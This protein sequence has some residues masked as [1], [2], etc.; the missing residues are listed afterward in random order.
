MS[1][2]GWDESSTKLGTVTPD[3]SGSFQ[4]PFKALDDL[5]GPHRIEARSGDKKLAQTAFTISPSAFALSP[6]SGSAGTDFTVHLKGG[7]WTETAN[8]YLL[9]YDN[10]YLGY[11]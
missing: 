11:A 8:I 1:G 6:A 2:Q 7:G 4:F 9:T 5:G 10:A 3:A